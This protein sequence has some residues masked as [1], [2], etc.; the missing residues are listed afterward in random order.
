MF[1]K[2]SDRARKVM[3]LANHQ[4][5]R[6]N[7]EYIGTE[8]ILLGLVQEGSGV[9]AAALKRLGVDIKKLRA[10]VEKLVMSGPNM[11]TRGKLPQTPRAKKV[12][13]FAIEEARS[14]NHRYIGTEHVLLGL[15]RENEGIAA[16]VLMNLG[17]EL[18]T[19]RR[20][21]LNMLGAG[22]EGKPKQVTDVPSF[23]SGLKRIMALAHREAVWR[24]H[25][26]IETEHVLWALIQA[27]DAAAQEM[28]DDL[29]VDTETLQEKMIAALDSD[30]RD[31]I[32]D[33]RPPEA[34]HVRN[35][36][37]CAIQEAVALHDSCVGAGHLLLGLASESEGSTHQILTDCGLSPDAVRQELMRLNRE[38]A[39]Q[40][41][42]C[43]LRQELPA[44]LLEHIGLACDTATLK[45]DELASQ[46]YEAAGRFPKQEAGDITSQMRRCALSVPPHLAEARR[47]TDRMEVKWFLNIAASALAE[48]QYLLDFSLKQGHLAE[49][50]YTTLKELSDDVEQQL[51]DFHKPLS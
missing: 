25:E 33:D 39:E 50:Q 1:E 20:E 28:L 26:H 11:V 51:R 38:V 31:C 18:E 49:E 4:A 43:V 27:G 7:H 6:L 30:G 14:M 44:D 35:A 2:F 34:S 36:L 29:N 40:E 8:H 21:V 12:I 13:E 37:R 45:A 10:E 23:S 24:K 5:Q 19:V 41:A 46:V 3:A 15:L 16:Q 32:G 22:A 42:E 48:L 47:R 9:G 17:L